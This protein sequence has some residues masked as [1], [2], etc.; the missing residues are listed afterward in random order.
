MRE[1]IILA[2]GFGTR[3][4]QV[5]RDV[6]KPMAPVN[7][8]PF[9]AYILDHLIVQGVTKLILSVGY[10]HEVIVGHFNNTYKNAKIF[11]SVETAPLG[12]GGAIKKAL[13]LVEGENVLVVNGDTYLDSDLDGLFAY[14]VASGA[15][16]TM[17]LKPMR[18][19]E[20]YGSVSINVSNRV[21]AFE[22]KKY[23]EQGLINAGVYLLNKRLFEGCDLPNVFSFENDFLE[24]Y[25]QTL[26]F[27]G[28]SVDAYFIDIGIPEDFAKSQDD[29]PKQ[30]G[31]IF[32]E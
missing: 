8:R 26:Q 25:Y 2:G 9:L 7:G 11:Y 13:S 5:V 17:T 22:E 16:L 6:P 18:D 28:F 19:F 1:A 30:S 12:T 32:R 3:L 24:K 29:F 10:K 21:V 31:G 15:D 27:K 20:R 4:Q 14:H 23:K